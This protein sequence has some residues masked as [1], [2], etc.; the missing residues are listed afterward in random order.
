MPRL[1]LAAM[2]A[3]L[4]AAPAWAQTWA[5]DPARSKLGFE[6]T[7]S[8]VRFSGSFGSWTADIAFDPANLAAAKVTAAIQTASAVTGDKDRDAALPGADWFAASAFPAAR[9]ET[10]G[11]SDKGGGA[12]EAS[13][14]LTIRDKTVPIT[15]P[16]TL[17]IAD[18]VATMSGR[19]A[20]DRTAFGVG[21]G[22]WATADPV[23]HD[24][25]VVV[26]IVATAQ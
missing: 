26:D 18:G 2:L 25:T 13:G 7:M 17:T 20:I 3:V 4:A 10:T 6:A 1:V 14:A 16:F 5:V 21:Q 9:F 22:E 15:L 24:V 19:V 11:F 8:G 23:A 12:Y